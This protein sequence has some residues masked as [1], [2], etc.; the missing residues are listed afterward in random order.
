MLPTV[1]ELRAALEYD[2]ETGHLTWQPRAEV[3]REQKRWNKRHAGRIAGAQCR[4]GYLRFKF[5]DRT[6]SAHRIA[7]A[8]HYGRWPVGEIDHVNGM[9]RDNRA[10]NL[11]E[12]SRLENSRNRSRQS[13]NTSGFK[14]VTRRSGQ[15][16]WHAAIRSG[17]KDIHLG[18][19]PTAE[20]AHS[21][22]VKAAAELH[23]DFA[24]AA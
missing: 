11:R 17:G 14:G 6:Y 3:S 5:A 20:A 13:N 23:G 21:A 16:R 2:P 10:E 7:F 24:R 15:N 22:Y 19:F 18:T 9:R 12:A 1:E 4:L 8:L